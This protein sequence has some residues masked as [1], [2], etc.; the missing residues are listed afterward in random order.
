LKK[1]FK[2]W[3][4][5]YQVG[6]LDISDSSDCSVYLVNA[7]PDLVLIDSGAGRSFDKLVENIKSLSF[8]PEK[9]KAIIITHAHIDHIGSLA[10]FKEKFGLTTIAYQLDA[11][12]IESG[13]EIGAEWYGITYEPCQVDRKLTKDEESLHYG[14]YEFK[15]LHIPGHTSGS[16][17]CYLDIS[18][19]RVLFG[20]DIHG[21]YNLPGADRVL[22]RRSLKK[23]IDLQADILCEGH[24]G[25]Y[26]PASEVKR[27]IERY[28]G[29]L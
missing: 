10:K 26:E 8:G 18:G 16:I 15:L 22:A 6:G 3:E 19:K 13:E 11:E 23:L 17:A 2:I 9:L 29:L 28:L 5:V 1:P 24:F 20:Q 4:D 14:E 12:K 7:K 27:Y 21:P 25:I